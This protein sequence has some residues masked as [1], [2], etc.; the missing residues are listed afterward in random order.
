[1]FGKIVASIFGCV[2]T[3]IAYCTLLGVKTSLEKR[4]I[5]HASL[6]AQQ[7]LKTKIN[8][9]GGTVEYISPPI[10]CSFPTFK[11]TEIEQNK[12]NKGVFTWDSVFEVQK[13]MAE[14]AKTTNHIALYG[15]AS[16]YNGGESMT[17]IPIEK[18]KA[19]IELQKDQTQGPAVQRMYPEAQVE[20]INS[21]I[22]EGM[23]AL[24]SVLSDKSK[25]SLV[26]G[27]LTP[28]SNEEALAIIEDL[29]KH[30]SNA[31]FTCVGNR[32]RAV[33]GEDRNQPI[34]SMFHSTVALG[35]YLNGADVSIE[36]QQE[37]AFQ[38]TLISYRALF[39]EALLLKNQNPQKDIVVKPAALGLGA[40]GNDPEAVAKAYFTA[41]TEFQVEL[42]EK[43]IKVILQ[44]REEQGKIGGAQQMA[45]ML[46]LE[47]FTEQ[48]KKIIAQAAAEKAEAKAQ[49][50]KEAKAAFETFSKEKLKKSNVE[51]IGDYAMIVRNADSKIQEL[52]DWLI[53]TS[54]HGR[55]LNVIVNIETGVIEQISSYSLTDKNAPEQLKKMEEL[56]PT[57]LAYFN[58]VITK[59]PGHNKLA[60]SFDW[61]G[62]RVT[63]F[64]F[65]QDGEPSN[66]RL[67][68][69]SSKELVDINDAANI[70]QWTGSRFHQIE[71]LL[72][73]YKKPKDSLILPT[74]IGDLKGIKIPLMNDYSP[75]K[76][77]LSSMYKEGRLW[78][79]PIEEKDIVVLNNR[80]AYHATPSYD[81]AEMAYGKGFEHFFDGADHSKLTE[82]TIGCSLLRIG[83]STFKG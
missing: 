1:V 60:I 72:F 29:K 30:G 9:L 38:A 43:G 15:A 82:A 40:F 56:A 79:S 17:P 44:V 83:G 12:L 47:N 62:K 7:W 8:A 31:Q 71:A 39:E 3:L 4:G 26:G 73:A 35:H 20:A 77:E 41:A 50:E 67:D 53:E 22:Y 54:Y 24:A 66:I 27:Y 14:D 33:E 25:G 78:C 65:H 36:N 11:T 45:T 69:L 58:Q 49:A 34:Y 48:E 23:N 32:L 2:P 28:K 68:A 55:H 42:N 61:R 6:W 52:F 19:E 81:V 16:Q 51:K 18:G 57:L 21:A 10:S 80:T 59:H 75:S 76:D 74:A 63:E 64:A 13:A 5:T 37:L 46:G 70:L